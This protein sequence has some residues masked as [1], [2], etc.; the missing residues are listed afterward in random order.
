[1]KRLETRNV[2][3]VICRKRLYEIFDI[4]L[5]NILRYYA[6]VYFVSVCIYSVIYDRVWMMYLCVYR[7][8]ESEILVLYILEFVFAAMLNTNIEIAGKWNNLI[9]SNCV[10]ILWFFIICSS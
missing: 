5:F 2:D 3:Y 9:Q 7:L 6:C 1:M 8:K 4:C 10:Y